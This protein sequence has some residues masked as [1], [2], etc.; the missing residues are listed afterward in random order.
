MSS[1]LEVNKFAGAVLTAGVLA[2]SAGFFAHT[3]YHP[4]VPEEQAYV[5]E[6]GAADSS[7]V[8]SMAA[9]TAPEPVGP[10]LASADVDAGEKLSKKCISCHSFEQ[11]GPTKIGPNLWNIVNRP[12]ASVEGFAYSD[13]LAGMSGE[14]W[15]YDNLNAFLTKP[16]DWVPGTKM[17]FPGVKGV[18]KRAGLIGFLRGFSDSPAPLPE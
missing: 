3:V 14:T 2:M 7:A 18:E 5:W 1:S 16:K 9:E 6:G 10:L 8:E 11:G 4:K 13:A 15:T 12:I 17:A